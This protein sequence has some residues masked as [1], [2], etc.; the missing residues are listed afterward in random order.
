MR[1]PSMYRGTDHKPMKPPRSTVLKKLKRNLVHW[2]FLENH[3]QKSTHP[4]EK[5]NQTN[6]STNIPTLRTCNLGV[7]PGVWIKG[8]LHE[9]GQPKGVASSKSP[10]QPGWRLRKA[11][12]LEI[13]A[14][15]TSNSTVW[16]SPLLSSYYCLQNLGLVKWLLDLVR[17][18]NFLK[19][20]SLVLGP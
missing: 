16:E 10:P 18:R 4:R 17:F 3:K 14:Q 6:N 8:C 7:Y 9:H 11:A 20:T 12:S 15:L 19:L 5:I 1:S 13:T 2:P